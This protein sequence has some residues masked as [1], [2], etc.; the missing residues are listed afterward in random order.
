MN[1][2]DFDNT[3]YDGE[4]SLDF[5]K[6]CVKHKPSLTRH[7]PRVISMAVK[8]KRGKVPKGEVM[9]FCADM[10]V[11]LAENIKS[12]DVMLEKFWKKNIYKLKP[13]IMNIIHNGDVIISASPSFIFDKI[14]DKFNGAEIISTEIDMEHMKIVK[15]CYGENKV[16]E[17]KRHYH[18]IIPENFYTDNINDMPMISFAEKSWIVKGTKIMLI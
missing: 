2:F 12:L 17:F 10:L 15:L 1:V 14:R 3:I 8:Y 6:F 11:I 16:E 4:S 7:L 18:G 13:E 5:F 9:E